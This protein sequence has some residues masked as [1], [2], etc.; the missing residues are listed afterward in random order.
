MKIGLFGGSFNPPHLMHKNIALK[1]LHHHYLD[2]VIYIPTGAHYP[3]AN[4]APAKTRLTM[5]KLML[6]NHSQLSVS[7][8]EFNHLTYTYQTLDHFQKLYPTAQ[9]YFICGTDNLKELTTWRHYKYILTN[10]KLLVIP[11][12]NDNISQILSLYPDYQDQ[13]IIADTIPA[14]YISSTQIRDHLKNNPS[15]S[16]LTSQ[17]DQDVLNYIKKQNLYQ[18]K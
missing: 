3:K 17:M 13:I 18:T 1:L 10:Y 5:L 12:N 7:D 11:R 9:I 16:L 2:Q 14:H 4:L 6:K 8:Y 15:S